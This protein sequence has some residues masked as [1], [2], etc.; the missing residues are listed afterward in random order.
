MGLDGNRTLIHAGFL[1]WCNDGSIF[2]QDISEPKLPGRTR[3]S[4]QSTGDP[5]VENLNSRLNV[6]RTGNAYAHRAGPISCAPSSSDR[7]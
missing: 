6:S 7:E 1:D 5:A 3:K 4:N 2:E